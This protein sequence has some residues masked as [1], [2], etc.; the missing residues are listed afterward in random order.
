VFTAK[1]LFAGRTIEAMTRRPSIFRGDEPYTIHDRKAGDWAVGIIQ[2]RF[3]GMPSWARLVLLTNY[4]YWEGE[5][6]FVDGSR[7]AGLLTRLLPIVEGGIGCSR[8]KPAQDAMADLRMLRRPPAATETRLVGYVRG[9]EA[10]ASGLTRPVKAPFAAGA[11]IHITGP[12]YPRTASTDSTGIYE[13]DDLAPGDYTLQISIPDTQV[14]GLFNSDGLPAVIHLS[15]GGV[16]ERNFEL[17]W[18]GRIEGQVKDDS[19]KP[20]HAWVKLISADGSRVPGYVN[21]FE[22]T[23]K[24]GS[25]KFRKIPPGR[26]IVVVN[27]DGPGAEW[28]YD[29]QYYP[30]RLRPDEARVLEL[31]AGQRL[32]GIDFRAPLLAE[33]SS[34]VRVTWANGTAAAGASVCVAYEGGIDYESLAG[35]NCLKN[36]DQEGVAV[37][38]TYGRSQVRVFA[39]QF[40]NQGSEQGSDVI[41]SRPVQF[42]ADQTPEKIGLVL[43]PTKH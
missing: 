31:A 26:Y 25:F 34:Q 33:R 35:G 10:F 13:L 28:P 20:A 29:L 6:Y 22:M 37:I 27:P 24:D 43:N 18:N 4:V 5:T 38:H 30:L 17:F 41:R 14:E 8:T 3:W 15:S 2:E 9:P 23:A 1:I 11:Q 21:S 40:V 19:G 32:V 39:N 42:A 7:Y 36:T 12:G 16:V